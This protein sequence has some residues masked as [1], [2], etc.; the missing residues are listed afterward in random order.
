MDP[1]NHMDV[2]TWL[3]TTVEPKPSDSY[4]KRPRHKTKPDRY[5]PRK[6][7]KANDELNRKIKEEKAGKRLTLAPPV[8]TG[9][10]AHGRHGK[11]EGVPDLATTEMKFLRDEL[12]WSANPPPLQ[13]KKSRDAMPHWD[14]NDNRQKA[15]PMKQLPLTERAHRYRKRDVSPPA[16]KRRYDMKPA[17]PP[18][19]KSPCRHEQRPLD[20]SHFGYRGEEARDDDQSSC[21]SMTS[22][23]MRRAAEA[24]VRLN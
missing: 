24:L 17:L 18:L 21:S 1:R 4:A 23:L 14:E 15:M 8:A 20:L 19:E 7:T 22:A 13:K 16:K 11:R 6:R 10:F 5:E 12:R 9:L 2:Q 3:Q